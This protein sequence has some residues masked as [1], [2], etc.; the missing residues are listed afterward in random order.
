MSASAATAATPYNVQKNTS[1]FQKIIALAA[2]AAL[3]AF[4]YMGEPSN[5]EDSPRDA[6]AASAVV[7]YSLDTGLDWMG[8]TSDHHAK[9]FRGA[10]T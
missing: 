3:G 7:Q 2:L 8:P 1:I 5:F 10:G 9:A 6:G 4:A